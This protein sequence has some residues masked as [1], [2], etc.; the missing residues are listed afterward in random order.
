MKKKRDDNSDE[1]QTK[2]ESLLRPKMGLFSNSNHLK[3][4]NDLKDTR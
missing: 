1:N 4:R 3:I 2:K